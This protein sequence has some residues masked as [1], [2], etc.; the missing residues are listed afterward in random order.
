MTVL[1]YSKS[2]NIRAKQ[3]RSAVEGVVQKNDIEICRGIESLS[4]MLRMPRK[5]FNIAV[6]L[7]EEMGD[8]SDLISIREWMEDLRIILVAPDGRPET[9]S[10]GH[11]LRPRFLTDVDSDFGN[12]QAVLRKMIKKIF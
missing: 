8:L 3:L 7:A 12:I 11:K 4:N 9:N 6:L 1:I 10:N 5:N 2:E